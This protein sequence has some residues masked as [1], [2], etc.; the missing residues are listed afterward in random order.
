MIA[1]ARGL[2]FVDENQRATRV[3]LIAGSQ[4]RAFLPYLINELKIP[5]ICS[6]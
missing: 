6:C 5:V 2:T 3:S 1:A 4:E